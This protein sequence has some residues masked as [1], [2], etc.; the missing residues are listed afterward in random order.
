MENFIL[1]ND[2]CE[3]PIDHSTVKNKSVKGKS[4][5]RPKKCQERANRHF[6]AD[7][8][9]REFLKFVRECC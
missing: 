6:P 2:S 9:D 1:N 7:D 4:K 5:E 3:E 8:L